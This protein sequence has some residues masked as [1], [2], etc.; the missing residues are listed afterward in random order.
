MR[1]L[2]DF[3]RTA[4]LPYLSRLS[5][6][7]ELR[8]LLL[9]GAVVGAVEGEIASVIAAK[10][11][12]GSN[13]LVTVTW[14][15]PVVVNLFNVLWGVFLRGRGRAPMYR[16]IAISACLTLASIF[17]TPSEPAW[18]GWLF[19]AQIALANFFLSGLVTLRTTIWRANYPVTHRGRIAGR[20]STVRLLIAA[21][22]A[23]VLGL[24]FDWNERAYAWGYLAVAGC[25]SLALLPLLRWR[26]RGERSEFRRTAR[27]L[28]A[29]RGAPPPD[30]DDDAT[31]SIDD[32]LSS[33]APVRARGG[34]RAGLAES[35]AILRDD[36]AFARYQVGMFLLGSANFF[37]GP[38]V[39]STVAKDLGLSYF[40]SVVLLVHIPTALKFIVI[41]F[42]TP[43]FD[44]VGVVR[45]RLTNSLC[46]ISHYVCL[47]AAMVLLKL[48]LPFAVVAG[49]V[50]LVV[51]RGLYGVSHGG[52][53]IAWNLGHLHFAPEHQTELYM[54]VH[55]ALTGA[56]GLIMPLL[57]YVAYQHLGVG[58]FV[59][60]AGLAGSSYFIFRIAD[61]SERSRAAAMRLTI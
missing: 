22:A 24:V 34:A 2:F 23:G 56:R 11:F 3:L 29:R 42:W 44:R 39:T 1:A 28:A 52:G 33:N 9:W 40:W 57:G 48:T 47:A 61:A 53:Q 43:Y 32:E 4:D 14:G 13:F 17:F 51:A 27:E 19:A 12:H 5:Y 38:A 18:G 30:D 7:Q 59:I 6:R 58:A 10:T 25:G 36:R 8:H 49:F 26:V 54:S 41:P 60:A 15:V 46:W 16:A 50:L 20:L 45:Y 31:A 37:T 55:V 35:F 21:I